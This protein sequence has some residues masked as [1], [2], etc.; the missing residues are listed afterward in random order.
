MRFIILVILLNGTIFGQQ[1]E[2]QVINSSGDH[3][4]GADFSVSYSIGET[5]ISTQE[6]EYLILGQGFLQSGDRVTSVE[7]NAAGINIIAYPNPTTD[8]IILEIKRPEISTSGINLRLTDLSGKTRDEIDIK[9]SGKHKI[10]MSEY[11]AGTYFLHI[12][13]GEAK[14]IIKLIKL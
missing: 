7:M 2:R 10:D 11:E 14:E 5:I 1:I 12:Y 13:S 6:S 9:S 3:Y 8:K 4:E